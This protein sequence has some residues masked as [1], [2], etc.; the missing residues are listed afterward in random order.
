[1][2]AAI[3]P[4]GDIQSLML[5]EQGTILTNLWRETSFA[6]H[7]IKQAIG[8]ILDLQECLKNWRK[9]SSKLAESPRKR[10]WQLQSAYL[11]FS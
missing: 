8:P 6:F 9:I 5:D 1:M 2:R 7:L 3:F 10:L 4:P 11:V